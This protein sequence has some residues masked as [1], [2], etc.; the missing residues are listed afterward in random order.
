MCS[1]CVLR[2]PVTVIVFVCGHVGGCVYMCVSMFECVCVRV[3]CA[4]VCLHN[5]MFAWLRLCGGVFVDCCVCFCVCVACL[6]VEYVCVCG[7]CVW[8]HKVVCV[9]VFASMCSCAYA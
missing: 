4:C 7:A 9:H 1:V 5:C 6:C 3:E 2:V 8:H